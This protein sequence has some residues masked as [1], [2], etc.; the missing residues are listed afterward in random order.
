LPESD[1]P[2]WE[3]SAKLVDEVNA[4][5]A[6]DKRVKTLLK[7]IRTEPRIALKASYAREIA[8]I[9]E[10]MIQRGFIYTD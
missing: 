7:L 1:E 6:M 2:E 10:G 9:Y 3:D 4:L 8:E 5:D